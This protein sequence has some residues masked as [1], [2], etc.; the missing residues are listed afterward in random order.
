[1]NREAYEGRWTGEGTSNVYPA[2]TTSSTPFNSRFTDFIVEDASFVRLKNVTLSYGFPTGSIRFVRNL[3]VFASASNLLTFTKYKGYDP[4]ISSKA[5]NS[6]MPGV[7]SGSIPQYRTFSA[8]IN[9]G[10]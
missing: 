10:F 1:V 6:M 3:K 9:I 4:E 2:P 7:D 8:G 5:D